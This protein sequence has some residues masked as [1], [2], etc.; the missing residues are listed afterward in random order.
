MK[1]NVFRNSCFADECSWIK[2]GAD[3]AQIALIISVNCIIILCVLIV[4]G[5]PN[6][7]K[8]AHP[9]AIN[10]TEAMAG[11]ATDKVA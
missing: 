2:A 8:I 10:G 5:G 11:C 4:Q 6:L 9:L 1:D 7:V 3:V